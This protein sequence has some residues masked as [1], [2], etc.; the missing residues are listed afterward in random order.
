MTAISKLS[1]IT[2]SK[3]ARL[4]AD[5]HSTAIDRIEAII[6]SERIDCDFARLPGYLFLSPEHN[7][8]LL[9]R[10]LEATRR[11]GLKLVEEVSRVPWPDFDTGPALYFP[12]QGQFHPL[13][14][15]AGLVK[16]I[17]SRGGRF[18]TQTHVDKIEGGEPATHPAGNYT[19]TADAVVVATNTP[20]NDWLTIHT[21]QTGYMTYVIGGHVPHGYLPLALFWDTHDPYHY[22]RLQTHVEGDPTGTC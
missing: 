7:E 1:A 12:Q 11:A 16:A 13:K 17:E 15:L 22:V 19:V 14:Y 6:G 4:A 9:H 21:K 3:G 20:V 10:E 2:A 18:F 5:S 8:K